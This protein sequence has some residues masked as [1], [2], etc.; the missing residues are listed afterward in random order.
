MLICTVNTGTSFFSATVIFSILGFMA[1]EKGVEI[2]DVVKSGPGLAFLVYPEVVG[3]LYPSFLWAL[4][5]FFMLF[6][7]GIDSQFC[8]AESLI[9]GLVDN[10]ASVLRPNRQKFVTGLLIFMFFLGMPMITQGGV[11]IFQLMDFYAASGMS[12]LWYTFFQ[13]IAISWVFGARKMYNCIELMIGHKIHWYWL[14]CWV[15]I[16]PAFMIFVFL[17]YFIKYTP[18]MYGKDYSYP[19][20]GEMLGFMIILSSMIWVPGYFVYYLLTTPGTLKERLILG[21][22]P[23]I[24]PRAD[25]VIAMEKL[26]MLEAQKVA[27]ND[28]EMRLVED[29]G[30]VPSK[31][32]VERKEKA[33]QRKVNFGRNSEQSADGKVNTLEKKKKG[34]NFFKKGKKD[35]QS[36]DE[37]S[38]HEQSNEEAVLSYEPVI[39]QELKYTRPVIILGPIKDRVNNDLIYDFPDKFGCC[40]PHTTREKKDD[41]IDG[42]D[43]YFVNSR[44]QMERDIQNHLFIEAGQF[45]GNLYGT[46]VQSVR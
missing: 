16:A 35:S 14:L 33:R 26:K 13:T 7:L 32:R 12:L 2:S 41:E 25:A 34:L 17:F 9:T 42:R 29:L 8:C 43:Y 44:E 23:V 22:T 21:I 15:G 28:L 1:K 20:W 39:Q 30:I 19:A 36:G 5:F 31:K 4:L 18:I 11:F 45:H 38:D 3:K 27:E 6:I 10:W 46:S 24:Q 40:V 37:L